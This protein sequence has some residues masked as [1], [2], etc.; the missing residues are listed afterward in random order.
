[1]NASNMPKCTCL[2][3]CKAK[4]QLEQYDEMM[5]VT[6]FLMGLNE[7][8][9]NIRGQLLMMSPMPHLPQVLALMQQEERQRSHVNSAQPTIK[10]AALM[11]KTVNNRNFKPGNGRN[12]KR[13]DFRKNENRRNN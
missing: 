12:D 1:M 2:C 7:L 8:Y 5:K 6:Q 11:S 9:T 3:V 10:S 13:S 4:S